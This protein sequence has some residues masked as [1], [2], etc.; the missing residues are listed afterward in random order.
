ML[1]LTKIFSK[2]D[3]SLL[4]QCTLIVVYEVSG[5]R[6]QQ[7]LKIRQTSLEANVIL[8]FSKAGGGRYQQLYIGNKIGRTLKKHSYL[9]MN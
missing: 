3:A 6:H 5:I 2:M 4:V 7:F 1:Y 9:C 8:Y